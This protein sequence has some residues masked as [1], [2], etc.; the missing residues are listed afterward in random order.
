M[1]YIIVNYYGHPTTGGNITLTTLVKLTMTI[2]FRRDMYRRRML[3]G[4]W[5]V[6]ANT[7]QVVMAHI[8]FWDAA[9]KFTI[10]IMLQSEF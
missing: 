3:K 1:I 10:S 8:S 9:L 6:V 2:G 4:F 5:P 7:S